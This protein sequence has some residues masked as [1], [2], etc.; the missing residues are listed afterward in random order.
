VTPE[1]PPD[2]GSHDRFGT[3]RWSLVL[4]SAADDP[5]GANDHRALGHLCRLYWR[6]IFAFI[7]RHGYS[8]ADAQDLTQDFFVSMIEGTLLQRANPTRG[9]FRTLLLTSLRNFLNDAHDKRSA[10]KRGGDRSFVSWENWMAETP[11]QLSVPMQLLG[12]WTPERLFDIRWAATMVEQAL[13]RLRGECEARG[14]RRVFDSL[15]GSLSTDP[16]AI[17]YEEIGRQLDVTPLT[18]KRLVYHLRRRYRA[19]LREEVAR[20]V[21]DE[22]DIDEEIRYLCAVLAAG[23]K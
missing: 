23:A 14:R 9:R 15:S 2:P 6:P 10:H 5:S 22:A 18:V 1:L 3:T 11:S 13:N 8:V 12:S 4:S 7:C 17:S 16:G 19:L 20:T 21:E